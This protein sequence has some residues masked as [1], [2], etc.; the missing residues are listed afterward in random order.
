MTQQNWIPLEEEEEELLAKVKY[1]RKKRKIDILNKTK[2]SA[3]ELDEV[4]NE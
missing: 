2:I 3:K 1:K 4:F